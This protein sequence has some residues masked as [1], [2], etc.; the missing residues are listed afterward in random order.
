MSRA[1]VSV[2]PAAVHTSARGVGSACNTRM[3]RHQL[4]AY[5]AGA[6]LVGASSAASAF[7]HGAHDRG[8]G[9][10]G[11][12]DGEGRAEPEAR[13]LGAGRGRARAHVPGVGRE[14][15]QVHREE[16]ARRAARQALRRVQ[17]GDD[18]RLPRAQA[19]RRAPAR[20]V[21]R[22]VQV[23][24]HAQAGRAT[25][26]TSRCCARSTRRSSRSSWPSNRRPPSRRPS[27]ASPSA[28]A[29][30]PKSGAASRCCSATARR[31]SS[32]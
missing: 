14:P 29:A 11:Q 20:E 12:A 8:A 10:V 3:R 1:V 22:V 32:S 28:R 13:Q 16:S 4:P 5:P 6:A 18:R 17:A 7:A 21:G 19:V 23:R 26:A 25:G 31:S 24:G 27:T 30:T 9:G 15:A 2:C